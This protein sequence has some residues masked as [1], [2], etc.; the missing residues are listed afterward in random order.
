MPLPWLARVAQA[1]MLKPG[2]DLED[3]AS[4]VASVQYAVLSQWAVGAIDDSLL[5]RKMIESVLLLT[6]SAT[7]GPAHAEIEAYL[8][9]LRGPRRRFRTL[10]R[11]AERGVVQAL[12]SRGARSS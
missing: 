1:K 4:M 7:S 5:P 8:E 11:N 3:L 10:L 9:D 2:V 6:A 12:Q